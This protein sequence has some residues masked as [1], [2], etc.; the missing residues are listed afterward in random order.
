MV[1][2]PPF[3]FFFFFSFCSLSL[4]SFHLAFVWV[5]LSHIPVCL[6]VSVCAFGLALFNLSPVYIVCCLIHRPS[7]ILFLLNTLVT[8][9]HQSPIWLLGFSVGLDLHTVRST[10]RRY[11]YLQAY[12]FPV[13]TW[14]NLII[15]TSFC[16]LAPCAAT[17][18]LN[19]I[20]VPCA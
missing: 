4:L 10:R 8:Y 17:L 11:T 7:F 1:S 14:N 12:A 20:V 19:S 2:F 9:I 15:L 6:S 16:W 3:S 18:K 5:Y 13:F